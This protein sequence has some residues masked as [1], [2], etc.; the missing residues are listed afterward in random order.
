MDS[1]LAKAI[2]NLKVPKFGPNQKNKGDSPLCRFEPRNLLSSPEMLRHIGKRMAHVIR[3]QCSGQAVVGLATSGIAWAAL[4]SRYSGLPMLYLRKTLEPGVS[5]NLLE[6]IPPA[7]GQLILIDDLIFNGDSKRR[8]ITSLKQ[9]GFQV[10]DVVVI[11][12][13]QLQR[14]KDGPSI[15]KT[16]MLKLHSLI[17]MSDI[18]DY[19]SDNNEITPAQLD[20]LIKDYTKYERWT[21]PRFAERG[22]PCAR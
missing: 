4:A 18:V 7:N 17:T 8:A 22:Q 20:M 6:G 13:R 10:S 19:M 21:M 9:L 2:V 14:K 16:Y 15:E 1:T 5:E 11:I 12:D 3:T